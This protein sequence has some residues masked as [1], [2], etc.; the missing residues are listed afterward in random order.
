M[1]ML[2]L[3]KQNIY[4]TW[5]GVHDLFEEGEWVTL[6]GETL[7]AAGYDVW[8]KDEPNNTDDNEHCGILVNSGEMN[9]I[10]CDRMLPFF[11]EIKLC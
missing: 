3:A 6:T 2:W 4:L 8:E 11:C 5:L 10:P 9:D 7:K 1:L